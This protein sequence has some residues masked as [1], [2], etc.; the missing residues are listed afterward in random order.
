MKENWKVGM[1]TFKTCIAVLLCLA[2]SFLLNRFP[3]S[4]ASITAIICIKPNPQDMWKTDIVR[5]LATIL[6]GVVG[7]VG[8]LVSVLIPYYD[9][10]VY[11][12]LIPLFVL[13][14]IW[15][16]NGLK[17]KD[18]VIVSAIMVVIVMTRTDV[19]TGSRI[20]YALDRVLDTIVGAVVATVINIF[21][22]FHF[23]KKKG[24]RESVR[25]AF[26]MVLDDLLPSLRRFKH[27]EEAALVAA[28]VPA[29]EE[30]Q[31]IDEG[32]PAV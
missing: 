2:Y 26:G 12:I 10:G 15:L 18:T 14:D 23:K 28:Q 1:R 32:K 17:M 21:M 8:I 22:P 6:G 25:A 4:T 29:E 3:V 11:V 31:S 16:C 20:L 5:C 9:Q 27:K 19:G 30:S 24:E 13:L 7:L